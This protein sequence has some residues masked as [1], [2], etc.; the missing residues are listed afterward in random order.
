MRERVCACNVV[1]EVRILHVQVVAADAGDPAFLETPEHLRIH[2]PIVEGLSDRERIIEAAPRFE[3]AIH[4]F[5]LPFHERKSAFGPRALPF[6]E[7]IA[8][9]NLGVRVRAGVVGT[10]RAGDADEDGLGSLRSNEFS[11]RGTKTKSLQ[12]AHFAIDRQA[13]RRKRRRRRGCGMNSRCRRVRF[14]RRR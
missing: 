9:V 8:A 2:P 6:V 3:A 1:G 14:G 10:E 5:G 12:R 13:I 7:E 4:R 11:Q